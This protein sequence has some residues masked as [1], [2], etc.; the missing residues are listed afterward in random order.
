MNGREGEWA[1][2]EMLQ[3]VLDPSHSKIA[4]A[5]QVEDP[6]LLLGKS[7]PPWRVIWTPALAPKSVYAELL[8]APEPLAEGRP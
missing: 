6:L 2:M 1:F 4:I 8:V 3:F 5:P 7:F